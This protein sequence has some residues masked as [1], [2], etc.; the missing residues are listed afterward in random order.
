MSCLFANTRSDA[1]DN[2]W[3]SVNLGDERIP[4]YP[5]ILEKQVVELLLT[6]PNPHA[7]SRVYNPDDGIR[8]L[9]IV[10]P[11]WS[12]SSLATDVPYTY[13]EWLGSRTIGNTRY[14]QI[15]SV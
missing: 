2:L 1:P 12:K 15:L 6:V 11:I 7:I 5:Y 9:E 4:N 10:P 14:K 8:L 3:E 13:G